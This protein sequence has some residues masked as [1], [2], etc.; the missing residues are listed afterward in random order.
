MTTSSVKAA[1]IHMHTKAKDGTDSVEER[2]EQAKENDLDAIALTD[3]DTI[4]PEL[5]QRVYF[6]DE[7]GVEVIRSAEIKCEIQDTGIEI[8]A[9]FL[10]PDSERVNGI[11]DQNSRLREQRIR[12]M[13]ENLNQVLDYELTK[14]GVFVDDEGNPGETAYR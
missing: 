7:T 3:H 13:I 9:Y 8:L 2:T 5:D 10:D 12:E 14:Q 6:D 11:L 4:N 1:D